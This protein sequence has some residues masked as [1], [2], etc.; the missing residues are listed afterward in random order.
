[1]IRI[2]SDE[3]ADLTDYVFSMKEDADLV[4]MHLD[5][6]EPDIKW[7]LSHLE[8]LRDELSALLEDFQ[9]ITPVE[10]AED[11]YTLTGADKLLILLDDFEDDDFIPVKT[12]R[13]YLH[14]ISGMI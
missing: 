12:I 6:E 8:D 2:T 11:E 4:H 14:R 1:M 7:A 5:D 13:A 3:L 10:D 9:S